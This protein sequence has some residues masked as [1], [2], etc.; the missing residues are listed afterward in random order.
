[1]KMMKAVLF[2]ICE[3]IVMENT[4]TS[5][6]RLNFTF[7]RSF[8]LKRQPMSSI[9]MLA[10]KS[11]VPLSK[12][13]L[14]KNIKIGTIYAEAFPRYC[15]GAGLINN[16]KD[17]LTNFGDHAIFSDS[18]LS[19]NRTL[20]LLHYHM[21]MIDGPGPEF[22]NHLFISFFK[23]GNTFSRDEI[24][25]AIATRYWESTGKLL[26]EKSINST[27]Y[28]FINSYTQEEGL[29]NLGILSNITEDYF[30]VKQPY[31]HYIWVIAYALCDYWAK[32][33]PDNNSLTL[34][35]LL[36]SEL[37]KYFFL[38]KDDF[39]AILNELKLFGF[40]EI[41]RIAQPFQVFLKYGIE[42]PLTRLFENG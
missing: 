16:K 34:D 22:W 3:G 40:L 2:V 24:K 14:L 35:R 4:D 39:E 37:P 28:A 12:K 5:L 6:E 7:H 9:C 1:M 21:S 20:W 33:Y 13:Y 11:N 26:A 30:E 19:D 8:A 18:T 23:P 17:G 38:S 42:F 29:G 31:F 15:Y 10:K 27:T 25:E 32:V 36:T 41:H